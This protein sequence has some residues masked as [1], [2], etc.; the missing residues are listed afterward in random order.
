MI[1]GS[2]NNSGADR[3]AL[4]S[5]NYLTTLTVENTNLGD[6]TAEPAHGIATATNSTSGA[7]LRASGNVGTGV[8]ATSH[9]QRGLVAGAI[10]GRGGD[11]CGVVAI[12]DTGAPLRLGNAVLTAVPSSG[13]WTRGDFVQV[14]G[15]LW[16]CVAS[17]TP[18]AWRLLASPVSAG[19]FVPVTTARIYD[20]RVNSSVDSGPG[21]L[22][23]G[24][25][26]RVSV[27]NAYSPGT[28]TIITPD[29][30]PAGARAV[31][32]NLTITGPTGPGYMFLGPGTAMSISGSTINWSAA[33]TTIA[34]GGIVPL[35]TSRRL[36][37][38]L[39]I[40]GGMGISHFVVDING[41]F[42]GH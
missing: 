34:N 32:V 20:S 7:A 8:H 19:A 37:A 40:S 23:S 12:S 17:G 27:A 22:S 38:F 1:Y 3:T 39:Q 35:D 24:A 29:L 11:N 9:G 4:V 25:S 10:Y 15:A 28:N 30:V 33:N 41:Y 26:R 6:G 36:K 18:G 42:L 21:P 13:T 14:N 2:L 31:A 5:S 16:F